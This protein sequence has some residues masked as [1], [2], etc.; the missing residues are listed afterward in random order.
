M[1]VA[2]ASK[3][4]INN[5]INHNL[6]VMI[7]AMREAR[8]N[9][10]E[11]IM[12]G[13]AFLQGFDSLKWNYEVDKGIA[14]SIFS[15]PINKICKE[16]RKLNLDVIFGYIEKERERISSSALIIERG[17]IVYNYK[18]I[19]KGW[20]EPSV[21]DNRYREGQVVEVFEY[22]HKRCMIALCGDLWVTPEL[23]ARNEEILFWPIYTDFT[24]EEWNEKYIEEYKEHS[25]KFNCNVLMVNSICK[26]TGFG[27]AYYFKN[28]E[29]IQKIDVGTEGII[30]VNID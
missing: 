1:R 17:E 14:L 15:E 2:L 30:I 24:L 4:F 13:E 20:K 10:A 18:R 27:G 23:F 3:E 25:R 26:P 22:R 8:E 28:G 19:S 21:T 7:E 16:S 6:N 5:D 11:V 9:G 12:F 29:I